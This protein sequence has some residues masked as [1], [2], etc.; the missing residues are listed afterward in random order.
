MARKLRVQASNTR[1]TGSEFDYNAGRLVLAAAATKTT[2]ESRKKWEVEKMGVC[3]SDELIGIC[4]SVGRGRRRLVQLI[5]VA[6][7]SLSRDLLL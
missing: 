2:A 4:V 7:F 6:L 1:A 5:T 3:L